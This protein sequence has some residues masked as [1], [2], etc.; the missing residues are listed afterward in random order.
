MQAKWDVF[1]KEQ[2][3]ICLLEI[4]PHFTVICATTE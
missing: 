2:I 1:I 4:T 3:L